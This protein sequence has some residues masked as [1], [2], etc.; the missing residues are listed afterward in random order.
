[1]SKQRFG[2]RLIAADADQHALA[3][4][5]HFAG[6]PELTRDPPDRRPKA[7]ALHPTAHSKFER[8]RLVRLDCHRFGQFHML[9]ILR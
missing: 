1:V 6:K 9:L 7:D 4:I 5:E 3:I 2:S 8:L